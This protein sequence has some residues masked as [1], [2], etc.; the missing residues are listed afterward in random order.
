MF[1]RR[2]VYRL[3]AVISYYC[4]G[5]QISFSSLGFC[6]GSVSYDGYLL[7]SLWLWVIAVGS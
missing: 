6:G 1:S 3:L 4:F 7:F 5:L 2:Q